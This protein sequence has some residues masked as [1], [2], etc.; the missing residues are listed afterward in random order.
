MA[1]LSITCGD[2]NAERGRQDESA[3]MDIEAINATVDIVNGVNA[4][5]VI[6]INATRPRGTMTDEARQALAIYELSICPTAIV[7]R[8]AARV[9]MITRSA[10]VA[11]AAACSSACGAVSMMTRPTPSRRQASSMWPKLL[12]PRWPCLKGHLLSPPI[13]S[14]RRSWPC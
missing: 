5:G 7:Q 10:A 8:A 4:A 13:P 1:A 2:E 11:A 12:A 9:G 14:L 3:V 6:V